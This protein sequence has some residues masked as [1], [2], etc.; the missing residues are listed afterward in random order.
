MAIVSGFSREACCRAPAAAPFMSRLASSEDDPAGFAAP[1]QS[2]D[3]SLAPSRESPV[4]AGG[5]E[6]DLGAVERGAEDCGLRD[7]A[8]IAA[9][10]AGVVDGGDRIV[11]ERIV[12]VLERQRRAAGKAHASMVAGA[13]LFID[14]EALFHHAL[15]VRDLF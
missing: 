8:A 12:C 13:D 4:P 7:L 1:L 15:P 14:A 6:D 3:D 11:F 9:T 10:D 5:V 2:A